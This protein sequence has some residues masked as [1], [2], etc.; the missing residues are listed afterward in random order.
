MIDEKVIKF[1]Y[2][3]VCVGVEPLKQEI[4]F[5]NIRPPQECGTIIRE[6]DN[7][8][9]FGEIIAI[10]LSYN[11]YHEYKNLLKSVNN[12]EIFAFWFEGYL[13]DF[14][15]WNSESIRVCIE[16]ADRAMEN[17]ILCMAC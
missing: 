6:D 5:Q 16:K 17:Y 2:G 9:R 7:V 3:E 10:R 12:K 14:S 11:T 13:F 8:E 15:N 1:G 4:T